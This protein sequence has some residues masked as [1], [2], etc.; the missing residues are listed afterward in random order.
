[1]R[2]RTDDVGRCSGVSFGNDKK[3]TGENADVGRLGTRTVG[4]DEVVV[5]SPPTVFNEQNIDQLNF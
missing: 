4:K 5:L 3:V 2:K 1:V